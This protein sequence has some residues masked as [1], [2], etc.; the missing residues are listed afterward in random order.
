LWPIGLPNLAAGRPPSGAVFEV[1]AAC[2][3]PLTRTIENLSRK[4]NFC[5]K[6]DLDF[7]R[8]GSSLGGDRL[9]LVWLVAGNAGAGIEAGSAGS[10]ACGV[11]D[12]PPPGVAN[13]QSTGVGPTI[14]GGKQDS[15]DAVVP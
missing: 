6:D 3:A 5:R 10:G 2:S 1:P 12:A 7:F 9:G 13:E 4:M 14:T 15:S 11:A 8:W